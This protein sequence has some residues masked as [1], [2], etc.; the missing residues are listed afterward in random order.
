MYLI[1]FSSRSF[2]R[3]IQLLFVENKQNQ[4]KL[5]TMQM[6]VHGFETLKE[7]RSDIL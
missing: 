5:E 1:K 6:L 7:T 4:L 2:T 3:K